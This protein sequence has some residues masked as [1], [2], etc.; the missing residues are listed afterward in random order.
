MAGQEASECRLVHQIAFRRRD[1]GL[2]RDPFGI[3][4]DGSDGVAAA[5]EFGGDSR[6]GIAGR[7][8]DG[9]FHGSLLANR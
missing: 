1:V 9:D 7:A 4:G 6:A 2:D 8:D 5:G 3:A